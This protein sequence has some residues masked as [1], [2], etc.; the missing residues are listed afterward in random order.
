MA[1]HW[2]LKTEPTTYSFE[3]LVRDGRATWDGVRNPTALRH[4]R[5]MT[6]G[7]EVLIYHSGKDPRVVGLARVTK[8]PYPDPTAGNPKI[9]V[10]DLAPVRP[11]PSP[12]PLSAIK[13]DPRLLT[14]EL[15]RISRLSVMPIS[16]PHWNIILKAGGIG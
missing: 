9:V 5:S 16:K 7:D 8:G 2:L 1:D 4:L 14:M 6:A 13:A 3:Q 15:V 11:L 12:V 10:V